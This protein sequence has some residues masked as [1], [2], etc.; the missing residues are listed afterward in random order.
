MT[1]YLDFNALLPAV[2][3]V[4][5]SVDIVEAEIERTCK[6]APMHLRTLL[7]GSFR[8][9]RPRFD[10]PLN[11]VKAQARE[12]LKIMAADGDYNVVTDAEVSA[13]LLRLS[14]M[15][16]MNGDG[17]TA[18]WDLI[19][20]MGL[21]AEL[22]EMELTPEHV[23]P[24]IA[25]RER[26]TGWRKEIVAAARDYLA[27]K[28]PSR[29]A[30]RPC[31]PENQRRASLLRKGIE[32]PPLELLPEFDVIVMPPIQLPLFTGVA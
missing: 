19:Q 12:L 22:A 26:F 1:E 28:L 13:A 24:F 20:G 25:E 11:L 15:L 30:P 23:L 29:D 14:L 27:K 8:T 7:F 4:F 21:D 16:P 10:M 17:L 2:A 3:D 5:A 31:N 32:F 9:L 6:R 18:Q